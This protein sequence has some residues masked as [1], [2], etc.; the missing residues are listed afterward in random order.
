MTGAAS[1]YAY[2]NNE[3]S[4]HTLLRLCPALVGGH[5]SDTRTAWNRHRKLTKKFRQV[6]QIRT[7]SGQNTPPDATSGKPGK[8]ARRPGH[9][10]L[11]QPPTAHPAVQAGYSLILAWFVKESKP[12]RARGSATLLYKRRRSS[13]GRAAVL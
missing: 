1:C 4:S 5:R 9:T 7:F 6:I 11:F 13:I 8:R 2:S 10:P 3:T 12:A